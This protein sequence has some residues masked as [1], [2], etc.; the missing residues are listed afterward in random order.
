MRKLITNI[1]LCFFLTQTF[2]QSQ[3][4]LFVF[5]QTQLNLTMFDRTAGN[6]PWGAGLGTT[7]LFNNKTKFKTSIEFTADT[8]IDDNK[9]AK[10]NPD[11]KIAEDLGNMFNLFGGISYY[12]TQ[13]IFFSFAAGPSFINQ[14]TL[15]GIKPSFC[16]NF[17]KNNKWTSKISFINIFNRDKA[18]KEDFGTISLSIGRRLF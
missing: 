8:Y 13:K 3:K 11:G 7:V 12:P 16:V 1:F 6:N 14:R 4:K 15:F 10:L 17:S 18:T 9:V 5:L 2:G